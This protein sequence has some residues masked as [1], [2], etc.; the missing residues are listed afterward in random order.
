MNSPY[1][2]NEL[3]EVEW[4]DSA[5]M[6]GWRPNEQFA[7]LQPLN[8]RSAGYLAHFDSRR[9]VL[10]QSQSAEGDHAEALVIPRVNVKEVIRMK[11]MKKGGKKKC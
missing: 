4:L 6:R 9:L 1:R 7:H 10:L 11:P 8:C 2:L 3:V 5:T